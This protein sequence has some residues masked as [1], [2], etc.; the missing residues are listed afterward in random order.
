[1]QG[2]KKKEKQERSLPTPPRSR[3]LLDHLPA[4]EATADEDSAG[5]ATDQLIG[6]CD[7]AALAV[8]DPADEDR[9]G[10]VGL[11]VGGC[12]ER[13]LRLSLCLR[14][15]FLQELVDRLHLLFL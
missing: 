5:G 7:P 3:D 1:M 8:V 14:C 15:L 12:I 13:E 10:P 6:D 9:V 4:A 11:I 2:E